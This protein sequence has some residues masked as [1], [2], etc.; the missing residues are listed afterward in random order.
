MHADRLNSDEQY[1]SG[2]MFAGLFLVIA[3]LLWLAHKT[4]S[5]SKLIRTFILASL[6]LPGILIIPSLEV[7]SDLIIV[8]A[9]AAIPPIQIIWK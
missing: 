2:F 5:P 6:I 7:Q 1:S 8:I 9:M 4:R 3:F